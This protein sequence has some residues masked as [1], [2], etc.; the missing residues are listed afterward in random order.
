MAWGK[1]KNNSSN[2]RKI[3]V[4]KH[5]SSRSFLKIFSVIMDPEVDRPPSDDDNPGGAGLN[6]TTENEQSM[7]QDDNSDEAKFANR[8]RSVPEMMEYWDHQLNNVSQVC[9]LMVVLNEF[10]NTYLLT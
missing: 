2:Q 1:R 6:E 3:P 7:E 5:L 4:L 8:C 10:Q 9:N